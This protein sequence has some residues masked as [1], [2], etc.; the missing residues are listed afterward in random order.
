M[1]QSNGKYCLGLL[2]TL[3]VSEDDLL[4]LPVETAEHFNRYFSKEDIQMSRRHIKNV[5][6]H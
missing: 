5:Q 1:N 4:K 2:S 3:S 6:H